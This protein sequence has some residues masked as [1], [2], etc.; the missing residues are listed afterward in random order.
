[1]FK[2][3]LEDFYSKGLSEF[4]LLRPYYDR[5]QP[6]IDEIDWVDDTNGSTRVADWSM[7]SPLT[8]DKPEPPMAYLK[9]F[10]EMVE[11]PRV[12]S[13]FK[14][15]YRFK[16]SFVDCWDGADNLNWHTDI[17]DDFAK[18]RV[19]GEEHPRISELFF[20]VY[21]TDEPEWKREYGGLFSYATRKLEGVCYPNKEQERF[22]LPET[23]TEVFPV[24]RQGAL[25]NNMDPKFVHRAGP[26][27]PVGQ[28]GRR[29]KRITLHVGLS[30]FA[31]GDTI[32]Y[33]NNG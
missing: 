32:D 10:Q 15:L 4:R 17:Y 11:D 33:E 6:L 22:I 18:Y 7:Y 1:M 30:L 28:D 27:N 31:P 2:F 8:K 5:L 3:N 16:V 9:L 29:P 12:I 13:E 23:V 24:N 26:V 21:L 14:D 19:P 20:L 25:V